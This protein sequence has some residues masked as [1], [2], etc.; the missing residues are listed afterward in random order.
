MKKLWC[1]MFHRKFWR[2]IGIKPANAYGFSGHQHIHR[3]E[4]CGQKQREYFGY[5]YDTDVMP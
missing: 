3:C 1:Q 2:E 5:E 4:K